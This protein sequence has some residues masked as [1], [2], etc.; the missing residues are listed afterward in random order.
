[1]RRVSLLVS[2]VALIVAVPIAY[3]KTALT[4]HKPSPPGQL[5]KNVG[6]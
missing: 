1:M 2:V 4:E 6:V 3:G 5:K